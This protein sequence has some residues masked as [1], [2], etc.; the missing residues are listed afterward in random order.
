MKKFLLFVAL[1]FSL[2]ITANTCLANHNSENLSAEKALEKGEYLGK[3]IKLMNSQ[4]FSGFTVE[5]AKG[6]DFEVEV[7]LFICCKT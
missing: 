2:L 1:I 4:E 5:E 3:G 7:A 6:L